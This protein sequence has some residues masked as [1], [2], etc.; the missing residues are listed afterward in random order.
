[1]LYDLGLDDINMDEAPATDT[2]RLL[3]LIC[4]YTLLYSVHPHTRASTVNGTLVVNPQTKLGVGDSIM[5]LCQSWMLCAM[6]VML[7]LHCNLQSR[8]NDSSM[9][10]HVYCTQ[11]T[12]G[13]CGQRHSSCECWHYKRLNMWLILDMRNIHVCI[14]TQREVTS[15]HSIHS[16]CLTS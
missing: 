7:R 4:N 12:R 1:M 3:V 14:C 8:I 15:E 16:A 13:T 10:P 5:W 6:N 2:T 9:Q 11:N